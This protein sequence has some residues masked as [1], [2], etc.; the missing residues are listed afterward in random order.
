[1]T[2]P[3]VAADLDPGTGIWGRRITVTYWRDYARVDLD[4]DN[5]VER[6]RDAADI[7]PEFQTAVE[8]CLKAGIRRIHLNG[9]SIRS[10]G[11]GTGNR[12]VT[13]LVPLPEV[14]ETVAA[15]KAA[16]L[17]GDVSRLHRLATKMAAPFDAWL[18]PGERYLR[19]GVDFICAPQQF[20]ATLRS[21][22][23]AMGL[24][25]NGRADDSGVWVRPTGPSPSMAASRHEQAP[26]HR[27][28]TRTRK[29]TTRSKRPPAPGRPRRPSVGTCIR[30]LP[31]D[32]LE[33]DCPCGWQ[34]HGHL[35]DGQHARWSLGI[36]IPP[37]MSFDHPIAVV[38]TMA[39]KRW[40]TLAYECGRLAR[41]DGG[42]DMVSF[43]HPSG[44]PEPSED[45][46]RAYLFATRSH[47]IGYLS[48]DDVGNN[49]AWDFDPRTSSSNPDPAIRPR[50]GLI[51]VADEWRRRGVA[52]SLVRAMAADAGIGVTDI[53]WQWPFSDA[54]QTLAQSLSPTRVW[55]S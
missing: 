46:L 5:W 51:F 19:L 2:V 3:V 31:G 9:G 7:R 13:L 38:D 11:L 15:L 6:H 40:R 10:Q 54:G 28:T 55:I 39:P 33:R 22:A 25:V 32:D 18:A 50:V 44:D 52:T 43:P 42:Y 37:G 12:W 30:Y 23:Q 17:D 34:G 1:V 53:A 8:L 36:P 49:A 29:S 24:R 35:H 45:N 4:R 26:E 16:E 41:A 20:L 27:D 47:V 14:K 48:A 21:E